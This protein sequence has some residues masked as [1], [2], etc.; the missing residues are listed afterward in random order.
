MD[1]P[2]EVRAAGLPVR[3]AGRGR[4]VLMTVARLVMFL[5]ATAAAAGVTAA[6]VTAAAAATPTWL[7]PLSGAHTVSAPFAPPA[8]RYG[9]GHRGADLPGAVDQ[10]VRAA[11]AGRISYA[12]L[13]AGRGVVVV[14]HGAL[15]T[16]YEPVSATVA[17]G[18]QVGAG[19]RIGVLVGGHLGCPVQACLHW[20]LRRG[21]AYLDPVALVDGGPVRLLPLAGPLPAALLPVGPPD[22][23]VPGPASAAGLTRAGRPVLREAVDPGRDAAGPHD[24]PAPARD[25]SLSAPRFGREDVPAATLAV[26]AL[27]GG[28]LLLRRPG[29]PPPPPE[30]AAA[31]AARTEPPLDAVSGPAGPPPQPYQPHLRAV[32]DEAA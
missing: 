7:W 31:A 6:G 21:D 19:D 27:L 2:G 15:R 16:T 22:R 26:A 8:H 17:V 1:G 14:V 3:T 32:P 9:I 12:G 28:I 30:T 29:V 20:G 23:A 11:G 5:S 10:P 24:A 13:L 25:R 18:T 4:A